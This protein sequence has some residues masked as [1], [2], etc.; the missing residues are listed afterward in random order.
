M[1]NPD[2]DLMLGKW[3]MQ[4]MFA[5]LL[6]FFVLSTFSI[7]VGPAGAGIIMAFAEGL[8]VV[9]VTVFEL[10]MQLLEFFFEL[11]PRVLRWCARA[12]QY[13]LREGARLLII[14]IAFI[15]ARNRER[16]GG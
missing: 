12:T 2:F 13:V 1:F 3:L 10:A 5:L 14:V 9:V 4:I 6:P 8:Q 7:M 11:A 16:R 15:E